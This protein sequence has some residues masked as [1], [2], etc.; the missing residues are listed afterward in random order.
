MSD[1]AQPPANDDDE[2]LARGGD[3]GTRGSDA[4]GV[5]G[6]GLRDQGVYH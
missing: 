4:G 3:L 5:Y 2:P 1:E 6:G